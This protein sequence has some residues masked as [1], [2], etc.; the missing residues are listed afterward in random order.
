MDGEPVRKTHV[1]EMIVLSTHAPM[2]TIRLQRDPRGDV[3]WSRWSVTENGVAV[4]DGGV[5]TGRI[6]MAIAES[7]R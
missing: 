3:G 6:A 5:G 1:V 2:R 7:L 4:G